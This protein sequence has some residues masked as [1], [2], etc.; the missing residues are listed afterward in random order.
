MK[1]LLFYTAVCGWIAG[2]TIHLLSITGINSID[3]GPVFWILHAGIVVV[4]VPTVLLVKRDEELRTFQQSAKQNR[5]NPVV[6]LKIVF[7]RTPTWLMVIAAAGFLYTIINFMVVMMGQEGVATDLG[8]T[9]VLQNHGKLIRVL[10][11]QE[12]QYYKAMETR[13]FSGH[14]M[15]FYGIAAAV[16]FPFN[17]QKSKHS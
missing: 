8:G 17:S 4:W 10:T 14:W 9:Y 7:R 16:L 5:V 3:T 12:Y 2:L 1:K 6:F 15:A 11:E 13:G